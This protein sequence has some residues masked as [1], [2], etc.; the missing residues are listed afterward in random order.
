M[1]H[2]APAL[3]TCRLTR[4]A[5]A[6]ATL[7]SLPAWAQTSAAPAQTVVVEASADASAQG[8]SK[9]FAGGQVARGGRVGLLGTQDMLDTPFA[10]TNYT[11][12]L[13]EDQQARSVA[14]VLLNDP[15]VRNARGF[16]NFQE[17]YVV[18]GFPIFSD[19]MAYNGLYGLLPRQYVAAEL[20][21][22]VEVFRGATAFLNG[23]APGGSGLGGAI[24]LLPKRATTAPLTQLSL[25]LESGGQSLVGLDLGRR[26]GPQASTG[27]RVNAVSRQGKTAIDGEKRELGLLSV[28]LDWRGQHVRLSADLGHQDHQQDAPRPSITP[29]GA[30][31]AAPE[32]DSN[33]A[34][35]WTAANERQT[36][37]TL[38]A[39]V[40]LGA[41]TVAWL[42]AG[43]REGSESNS[44]ALGGVGAD[45][46]G[47]AYRFDNTRRDRVS[48]GE[49]GL[50]TGFATG[51]VQHEL[52]F[53]ASTFSASFRNAYAFS[54]FAG[55]AI[56]IFHPSAVAAPSADF[57]VG[58]KL[59]APL[60]TQRIKTSSFAIADGMSL[61][62]GR[63]R[64]SLG[65][66]HQAI[67]D[68]SYD[69]NSGAQTASYDKSRVTPMAG[70]LWKLSGNTSIYA[71]YI[72]GLVRGDV[73]PTVA[74]TATVTNGGQAFAPMQTEQVEIGAKF[75]FGRIGG[76]MAVFDM[77]KPV[78]ATVDNGNGTA[79]YVVEDG[80]RHKG[81][82]LSVFGEAAPGLKLLGGLSWINAKME[83]SG[84]Q[85]I[86]VPRRQLS[87]GTEWTPSALPD[88]ALN[89][90]VVNTSRQ[91]ADGANTQAV[92]AWTRLDV[93]LRW[94][95][96]V[97]ARPLTL[98]LRVDNVLGKNY[99]ASAGG[100]PGSNYLV[101]GAPRTVSLSASID[102]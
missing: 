93:G 24:N 82:E 4:L 92:P 56:D 86:G 73:A 78:G 77:R 54:N 12:A 74:G 101:L 50:R 7:C 84:K 29:F 44:L 11:A 61:M 59:D 8:L 97:M 14:D 95:T 39:E 83:G 64:L 99:W 27:V 38:R 21:E 60:V 1:R 70:V 89:A 25:G 40:D 96:E 17:L 57:F 13:L 28:G 45:G 69:Y 19:D 6:A 85:A 30:V 91:W 49:L 90:R 32:A 98:R 3:A 23:A 22:R 34:Q 52:S 31:P 67:E 53:S 35:P 48:T 87:L 47:S 62:D 65:A 9:P 88:L 102:I 26:F 68:T 51:T 72:E 80:Q 20:L 37:G 10:A 75:D 63:L 42:A 46:I 18:R 55:F 33:Y 2:P 36:F 79:T 71:N 43:M 94:G 81:F 100:Y 66:R 5:L 58:G 41:H 76:S 16:G 15:A